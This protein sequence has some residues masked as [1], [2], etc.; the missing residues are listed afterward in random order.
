[1]KRSESRFRREIPDLLDGRLSARRRVRLER[2]L[3]ECA[4]C[5][6]EWRAIVPVKDAVRSVR[7]DREPPSDLVAQVLSALD[8]EDQ[9]GERS[10][11][12][13]GRWLAAL[14]AAAVLAIVFLLARQQP[15]DPSRQA[16]QD[17]K[18]WKSGRVQLEIR[19]DSPHAIS[20]FFS[21]RDIG[22][23]VGAASLHVPG[24][25]LV[26]AR[27]H[28]LGG[29][30][31]AFSVYRGRQNEILVCQMYEGRLTH[32]SSPSRVLE[33]GGVRL[34]VYLGADLTRVAWQDGP[35]VCVIVSNGAPGEVVGLA[36]AQAR[37]V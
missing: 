16:A 17:W 28:V 36:L 23:P 7:S 18:G 19:S 25:R 31:S 27:V 12:V 10:L 33:K 21:E 34:Y 5:R 26:G 1:M 4:D 3:E 11:A 6:R 14:A 35:L 13:Q 32:L 24:Y 30:P 29:H 22:F 8:R 20:R 37:R 2:H 15:T 9:L